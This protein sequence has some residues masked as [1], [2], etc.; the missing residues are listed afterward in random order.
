MRSTVAQ[1]KNHHAG[2]AS[3][4]VFTRA[5]NRIFGCAPKEYRERTRVSSA[6]RLRY[7]AVTHSVSP[8]IRLYG[9]SP[10]NYREQ[11]NVPTS[12]IERKQLEVQQ[13]ILFIQRRIPV[14][15]L[16]QTMGECFSALYG[17]GQQAGLAIAGQPISRYVTT[18]AGRVRNT[19]W[20]LR[21][22][23]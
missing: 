23:I 8:C 6:H 9:V 1:N 10:S 7:R 15:Q 16:Q 17:Y 20:T 14:R 2:C 11:R 19:P 18:G 12:V 22:A 3:H 4:E 21:S 5:F 13:P